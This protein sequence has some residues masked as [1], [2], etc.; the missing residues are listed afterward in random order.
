MRVLIVEDDDILAN[1]LKEGLE[2]EGY[3][4]D[5]ATNGEDGLYM[6]EVTPYD[7]V[8]LDIMLPELDG[9]TVLERLR[10]KGVQTPVLILTAK[11]DI[12]D[13]VKGLDK[14]A[15][16]YI[17]KPFE[18]S[19]LLARLRA[20]IRRATGRRNPIIKIGNIMINTSSHQVYKD[21]KEV[22]LSSKEYAILLYLVTNMG[23]VVS[24]E[25]LTEHVYDWEKSI[26]SNIIDV[27]INY[28]RKKHSKDL[29]ETVRGVGYI[30]RKDDEIS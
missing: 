9:W 7:V 4:V 21:G 3:A 20:L 27:Y 11:D 16:D 12:S 22:P 19:E 5:I 6:A 1:V 15:D 13:K 29:I 17:T 23:R 28:L 24:R 30:I 2:E 18:F 25:E 14:G 10:E 8:I 26:E